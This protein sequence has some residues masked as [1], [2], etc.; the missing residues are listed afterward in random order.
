MIEK[1]NNEKKTTK[2]DILKQVIYLLL[3]VY[4]LITIFV[5]SNEVADK[6]SNTSAKVIESAVKIVEPKITQE[7][8]SLKVSILQPIIRKC[9]HYTLYLILGFFTYNLIRTRKKN[10]L[11]NKENTIITYGI[12]AQCFC[13][14]YAITDE[15]HQTFIP[16]RSGEVRDVLIDSIGAFTGI[17]IC[18]IVLK[19]IHTI[20]DKV[21]Q[22]KE[23][24]KK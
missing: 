20:I 18:I 11:K 22:K 15:I 6:S 13:T 3:V 17:L 24:T 19:I 12:I 14:L 2:W 23:I 5:F 9:A 4:V 1:E 8:L 7:K 10:I 21:K 16:G